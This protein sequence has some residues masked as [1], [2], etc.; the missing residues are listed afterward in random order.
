MK[1]WTVGTSV[2][3]VPPGRIRFW[4]RYPAPRAGLMSGVPPGLR[5]NLIADGRQVIC[6][7]GRLFPAAIKFLRSG[8]RH[9]PGR[10]GTGDIGPRA[11]RLIGGLQRAGIVD[12]HIGTI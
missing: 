8:Q 12:D 7:L 2:S 11:G 4:D 6:S 9:R 10:R 5:D 3:T 1:V